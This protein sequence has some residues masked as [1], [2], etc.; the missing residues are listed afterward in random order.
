MQRPLG[1]TVTAILM[2]ANVVCDIALTFTSPAVRGVTISPATLSTG[3]II[4][5]AA[6]AG[7]VLVDFAFVAFYW[8][9]KAWARWAVVAGCLY[10]LMGLRTIVT[11]W[12][13]RPATAW[14][15]IA[16]SAL[17]LFLLVYLH[18]ERVQTWFA[19][20]T[21]PLQPEPTGR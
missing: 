11:Q 7:L 14:L 3:M 19:F 12:Q 4:F 16:S 1:I 6:L 20:R 8:L 18:T 2:V 21:R 5:H 9:G 10:Y 13:H 17:A 15:T